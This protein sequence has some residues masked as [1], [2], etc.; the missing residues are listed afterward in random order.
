MRQIAVLFSVFVLCS[1]AQEHQQGDRQARG[2]PGGGRPGMMRMSPSMRILDIDQDGVISAAEILQASANLAKLDVNHDGKITEEEVRPQGRGG[3]G[4]GGDTASASPEETVAM[5][6]KF[7]RN[8]D[9]KLTKDE[10]PE[11]MQGIFARNDTNE[12]G[13][14]TREELLQGATRQAQAAGRREGPAGGGMMRSDPVF[15]ALDANQDGEISQSEWKVAAK[16]LA[17]LDKNGDGQLTADEIRPN[18]PGR[19]G[20]PGGGPDHDNHD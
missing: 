16:V 13:V 2:G 11:R 14:L 9:G 10:V 1:R 17:K 8:G 5:F 12:D 3:G 7:D 15:A 18:F 19:G 6:M 4:G 20:R